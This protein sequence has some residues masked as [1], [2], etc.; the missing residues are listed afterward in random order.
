[1]VREE[2]ETS[3]SLCEREHE[4]PKRAGAISIFMVTGSEGRRL[5]HS[6]SNSQ[7][8]ERTTWSPR[9]SRNNFT[10][11]GRQGAVLSISAVR[12]QIGGTNYRRRQREKHEKKG[13]IPN[14]LLLKYLYFKSISTSNHSNIT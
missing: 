12:G 6:V 2:A 8:S 7:R 13:N 14:T 10:L 3:V 9:K 11:S 1:M 5:L 4:T